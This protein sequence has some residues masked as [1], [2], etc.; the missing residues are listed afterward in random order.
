MAFFLI[1]SEVCL[2]FSSDHRDSATSADDDVFFVVVTCGSPYL[3]KLYSCLSSCQ[4]SVKAWWKTCVGITPYSRDRSYPARTYIKKVN[5]T[6]SSAIC[7]PTAKAI[8]TISP[9]VF[10]LIIDIYASCRIITEGFWVYSTAQH[11]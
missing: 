7:Q 5:R 11:V 1:P 8:G 10:T 4:T 3:V 9:R 6:R 2:N